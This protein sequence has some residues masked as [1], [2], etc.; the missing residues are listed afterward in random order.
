VLISCT[1]RERN[2]WSKFMLPALSPK[3]TII[4]SL[5]SSVPVHSR[6]SYGRSLYCSDAIAAP[7][8]WREQSGCILTIACSQSATWLVTLYLTSSYS[9]SSSAAARMSAARSQSVVA[10]TYLSY[11]SGASSCMKLTR[12]LLI[13][14]CK[15]PVA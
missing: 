14:P 12:E 4:F 3:S 6:W 5:A 9:R 13:L 1:L 2:A 7:L 15:V 8:R 11:Q 10:A